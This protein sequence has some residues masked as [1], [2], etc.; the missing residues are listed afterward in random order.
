MAL[1]EPVNTDVVRLQLR[2]AMDGATVS[3]GPGRT[4]IPGS[5]AKPGVRQIQSDGTASVTLS[6]PP[7]NTWHYA[8]AIE[9]S[10]GVLG[11]RLSTTAPSAPY[12]GTGGTARTM[13]GD[14]TARYLMSMRTDASG[15]LRPMSHTQCGSLGNK[16]MFSAASAAGSI[17]IT[18][19]AI[20]NTAAA[21]VLDLS[22]TIPATATHVI[23]QVRNNSN[24]Q[25]YI[26]NPDVAAASTTNYSATVNPGAS[27]SMEIEVSSTQKLSLLLSSTG[28]LG[29]V[30]ALVLSGNVTVRGQGY[31]DD[32]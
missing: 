27:D 7:A 17:P 6:S 10:S 1:T 22:T 15:K 30:L 26:A 18:L 23:L 24:F 14:T 29:T 12:P 11:L 9:A 2:V 21:Q 4:F 25:V 5:T 3:V 28:L 8:Y 13:T 31:L 32:R 20:T 16:V 19:A